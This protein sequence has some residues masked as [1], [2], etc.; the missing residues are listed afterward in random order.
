M[1][2]TFAGECLLA[3]TSM[4]QHAHLGCAIPPQI[5]A[6]GHQLPL[7]RRGAARQPHALD[8]RD[9]SKTRYC[10]PIPDVSLPRDRPSRKLVSTFLRAGFLLIL[11][12]RVRIFS[13][14]AASRSGLSAMLAMACSRGNK[15]CVTVRPSVRVLVRWYVGSSA[16]PVTW[17][18]RA[19]ARCCWGDSLLSDHCCIRADP[20]RDFLVPIITGR[21]FLSSYAR[22]LHE[23]S[24]TIVPAIDTQTL[25]HTH[26][27]SRC[28]GGASIAAVGVSVRD[29]LNL[30]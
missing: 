14:K 18:L 11:R 28:R 25:S 27:C 15:S 3:T 10:S 8:T 9:R 30:L 21:D 29:F 12:R 17:V 26:T 2:P 24:W 22:T 6:P 13:W 7:C 23:K 19:A 4:F 20:D 1:I 16:K 5:A